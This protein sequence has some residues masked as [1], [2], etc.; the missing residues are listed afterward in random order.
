[1]KGEVEGGG[2]G[3]GGE[4]DEKEMRK[5]VGLDLKFGF[6]FCVFFVGGRAFLRGRE[7]ERDRRD[8][9]RREGRRKGR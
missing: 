4:V 7:G 9:R 5:A 8:R 1:M 3:G 2:G 6:V